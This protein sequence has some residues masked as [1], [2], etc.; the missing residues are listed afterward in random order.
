MTIEH[1]PPASTNSDLVS[2]LKTS[3]G[4]AK[5]V[6]AKMRPLAP[7]E[8]E[9]GERAGYVR[10]RCKSWLQGQQPLETPLEHW[11]VLAR[12]TNSALRE[13][14]SLEVC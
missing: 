7:S 5:S 1:V 13:S 14:I 4:R 12:L 8:I 2:T 9:N 6:S 10:R 11:T 3:A